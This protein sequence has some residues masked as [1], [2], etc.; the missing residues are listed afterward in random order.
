MR[1]DGLVASGESI[2]I[3]DNGSLPTLVLKV[4]Y[5]EIVIRW[6]GKA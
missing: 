3:P 6:R 1:S 2:K 4:G 5:R